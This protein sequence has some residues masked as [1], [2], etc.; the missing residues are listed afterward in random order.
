MLTLRGVLIRFYKKNYSSKAFNLTN[1]DQKNHPIFHQSSPRFQP[2]SSGNRVTNDARTRD[3]LGRVPI[4]P[5]LATNRDVV[6]PNLTTEPYPPLVGL[7]IRRP[8]A[9]LDK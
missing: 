6:N 2:S 7:L 1:P 5:L 3:L 4:R 8:D 9:R